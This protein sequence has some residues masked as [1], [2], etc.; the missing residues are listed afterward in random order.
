M[1]KNSLLKHNDT[2]YRVLDLKKDCILMIDCCKKT[3]P[4]WCD[5]SAVNTFTTC[6]EDELTE[7]TQTELCDIDMLDINSQKIIHERFTIIAG[8][9]PFISDIKMRSYLINQFADNHNISKQTVR[10]Y[11]CSYLAY[12]NISVLAPKKAN[13]ERLLSKDEKNI[14]WALNK[15]FY[16][17]NKNSLNTAYVMML[18]EKYSDSLGN[19]F[20]NYPTFNQFRYFYRK[21]R[22]MQTYFISRNGLKDYQRNNRPLIGDG[23]HAFAPAIG[24]GMLDST[25]CD[26]YLVDS[27]NNLVGRPLLTAC[28]DAFSGLCCGYSLSW[29]GGVYSLRRLM[30]N[31][32][33]NKVEWCKKYGITIQQKDWD[34]NQ[35]PATLV[36]DK[37]SE[38]KSSNFEQ[39]AELGI[40]LV[41]LPAYRPEL[42]GCVEKFFDLL[43]STFKPYLK[44]KGVIE[45]DYQQRGCRDYRKDACLTLEAFETIVLRCIIYYNRRRVIDNFPYSDE[46][47]SNKI[48]PHS[49]D[50]WNWSKL[51]PGANLITVSHE[52]L[53]LTLLPRAT[54]VFTRYGLKANKMRYYRKE[55]TE[56]YLKGGNVT[57]AYNP[58]NVTHIWLI[59]NGAFIKFDLIESR[60]KNKT[61]SDVYALNSGRKDIVKLAMQDN[62]QAQI[63][64]ANH[65]TAIANNA[66]HTGDTCIKAIRQNRCREQQRKHI[67]HIEV[68]VKND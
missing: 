35:I 5:V 23:V 64:L 32:I 3:M 62:L 34:C 46:M 7:L 45:S 54:G 53:Q 14:R 67:Q 51:Q 16:T 25:I 48:P 21:H 26:I 63:E 4:V 9:L 43:Q 38:Y 28:I 57:V 58:D 20:D 19:L 39:I 29:E 50:I 42:K 37:G 68:G 18:K 47:L 17:K 36:T 12:Q 6:N 33:T 52:Q 55:Y 11:L 24:V 40:T 8:I 13:K 10:N 61:L 22:N 30:T 49:S 1:Q 56:S 65:I 66:K 15:F 60:F 59:E 2:I 31:I 27:S 41:N 44:G